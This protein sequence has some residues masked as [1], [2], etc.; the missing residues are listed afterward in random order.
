MSKSANMLWEYPAPGQDNWGAAYEA[1][2]NSIDRAVYTLLE[3]QRITR[4]GGGVMTFVLS[5]GPGS[6][7]TFAWPSDLYFLN[8]TQG[9]FVRVLT[10]AIAVL[11]GESVYIQ[12]PRPNID[13]IEL[14]LLA[15]NKLDADPGKYLVCV[16]RNDKLYFLDG[17]VVG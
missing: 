16:R 3:N 13:N 9:T 8:P 10:G 12:I 5:G 6:S 2:V 1:L 4:T 7:G 17:T 14:G 11:E 15:T